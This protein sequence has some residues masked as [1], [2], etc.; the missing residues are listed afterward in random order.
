MRAIKSKQAPAVGACSVLTMALIAASVFP[1]DALALEW[2]ATPSINASTIATDN[3]SQ[4]ASDSQASLITTVSPGIS[5]A[6]KGSRRVSATL[7]YR[8]TGVVRL[9]GVNQSNDIFH[10]LA[11]NGK[12]ELVEDFL[13]I[14][15]SANVSQQLISL[16]GSPADANT[17]NANNTTVGTYSISP[18][19]QKRFGSFANGLLRYSRTGAIFQNNVAAS[20]QSDQVLAALTSGSRFDV[21]DWS[22]NYSQRHTDYGSTN[23]LTSNTIT[24]ESESATLGA[25]LTRKFRVFATVG[26][27]TNS[28][29]DAA[30]INGAYYTVGFG[31]SPSQRT[32]L[33]VSAGKRYLGNTFS[34]SFRHSGHFTTWNAV[35]AESVSD[36]SQQSLANST[37]TYLQCPSIPTDPNSSSDYSQILDPNA[38]VPSGCTVLN[39]AEYQ[40]LVFSYLAQNGFNLSSDQQNLLGLGL[41]TLNLSIANGVY[42]NKTFRNDINWVRRKL[43]LGIS[44]FDT[45]R[46]F[47]LK[48]S[49]EDHYSGI[50]GTV[51]Y[52]LSPTVSANGTLSFTNYKTPGGLSG[53]TINRNDDLYTVSVGLNRRFDPTLTGTLRF[54]HQTRQSND[55]ASNFDSNSITASI[56]KTF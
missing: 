44:I 5:F 26:R 9:G 41:G 49:L 34:L 46:L 22:L 28:F 53:L 25:A 32:S 11:A 6:S 15:G 19:A 7:A 4:S 16:L 36:F 8:A 2:N 14:D 3:S 39:S 35:Y 20:S 29:T 1:I 12:A 23:T 18:Y 56:N 38:P 21:I 55:A 45:R 13:Y 47:V 50:I 48:S 24:F 52:R 17:N 42:I 40:A 27:D 54:V 31:W 51:D 43:G 33:Q 30:S 10:N 37:A